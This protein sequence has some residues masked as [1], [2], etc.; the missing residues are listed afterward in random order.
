MARDSFDTSAQ[1]VAIA[2]GSFLSGEQLRQL[3]F[4]VRLMILQAP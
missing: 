4:A 2:T 3:C 1:A